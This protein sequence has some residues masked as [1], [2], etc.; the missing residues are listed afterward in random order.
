MQIQEATIKTVQSIL[1]TIS[2]STA[3]RKIQLIRDALDKPKPKIVTI[4]E[5]LEYFG[6]NSK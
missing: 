3:S 1:P 4:N 5:F 2:K 6:I